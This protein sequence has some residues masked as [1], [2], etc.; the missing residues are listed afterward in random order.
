MKNMSRKRLWPSDW[1]F[2][3]KSLHRLEIKWHRLVNSDFVESSETR[4]EHV[5]FF[6][7]RECCP[8]QQSITQLARLFIH[9]LLY[10]TTLFHGER[11]VSVACFPKICLFLGYGFSFLWCI[12]TI[13]GLFFYCYL[14][15]IH[16]GL[17][18]YSGTRVMRSYFLWF[19]PITFIL[20]LTI[21]R[22][23][24][25]TKMSELS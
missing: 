11:C 21:S 14:F 10:Y 24:R 3:V 16:F 8:C 15:V 6:I 17:F 13:T 9:F 12:C 25:Y 4:H 5:Q 1:Y 7:C 22:K 18:L 19:S 20:L 23:L 2:H